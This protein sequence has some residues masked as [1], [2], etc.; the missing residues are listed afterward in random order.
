MMSRDSSDRPGCDAQATQAESDCAYSDFRT[1]TVACCP[2]PF[3]ARPYDALNRLSPIRRVDI[4]ERALFKTALNLIYEWLEHFGVRRLNQLGD[5]KT[6]RLRLD[7]HVAQIRLDVL[8]EREVESSVDPGGDS[9]GRG[10]RC[11]H[12]PS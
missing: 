12:F 6:L 7:G 3:G 5:C 10:V 1:L 2:L 4:M 11:R 9:F 8:A